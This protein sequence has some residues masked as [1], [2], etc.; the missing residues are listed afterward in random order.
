MPRINL[1]ARVAPFIAALALCASTASAQEA[2]DGP[3]FRGGVSVGGGGLF[4]S[5]YTFGMGG[6]D[7][8]LGVQINNL[9]GVYAQPYLSGGGGSISGATGATGTA[10][11]NLLVDFTFI[12]QIFVG[13]GG[14]G[15][16]VGDAAAGQLH[17]R[18][19]GYPLMK[20]GDNGIRRKGLMIGADLSV[21][22]V[23]GLK[24]MQPMFS[25]GYEAY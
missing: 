2:P 15:G 6:V 21:H 13:A 19:G 23:D 3:R 17:L 11:V 7:G 22:F 14:G 9:I 24:L 16:L 1:G 12:D 4:I 5:G 8:R 20:R 18:F 25:I 10:G